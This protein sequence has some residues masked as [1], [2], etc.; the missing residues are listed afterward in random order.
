VTHDPTTSPDAPHWTEPDVLIVGA[1]ASGAA[2]AW[3]L[4][5]AG[6]RVVCLDQGG[7]VDPT[8]MPPLHDDWELRRLTS[9]SPDPNIRQL[10]EDY[11]VNDRASTFTPLMYNAVGGSTIHWSGHFPRYHP[12]DFRVHTLDGVADDWPLTYDELEP[13]FDLNDGVIGVSGLA[14]D[15]SQPPR[16]PR[17]TRP[18]PI[19]TMGETI[20]RGFDRLGWHWWVSDGA[21]ISEPYGEHR[22]PC[23]HC[24]P[25]DLGCPIAARSSADVTYWPQAVAFGVE[26]RTYCRVRE[27]T[28]DEQGRA[29][30]ALY[31]DREG[32]L[33][34]QTAP[35][36]I[37]ACNGVGTP[38][39]LLNSRSRHFPDGLANGS[40]L[41][42]KNLMFHPV[43]EVGGV[44]AE[45]LD[46]YKG[47]IGN[48]L[49]SH[50]FYETDL[51]R[52]FVRGYGMQV[53]RQ[54]G[55][56][57][58]AL[59]GITGQRIPWGRDHHRIFAERFK[60][61]AYLGIFGE[62]LPETI[63][64]VTLDPTLVD[65]H[66]IPAPLVRYRMSDNSK[67][68]MEHGVA[69]AT[70]VMIAAGATEVI[71]T[72]PYRPAGWHLLGTCRM[73]DHPLASV[74]DRWGRSHDVPNLY[75]VDGSIFV[76]SAAVNPTSTI[77][78]LALRTADFIQRER[79]N[80]PTG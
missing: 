64:D 50:E 71:S 7:W 29:R 6:F 72:N 27:I 57:N 62:D 11:P 1:G 60:H 45:E 54:S 74:V 51:R 39:L 23:N 14:G 53:T 8:S 41:V 25:C 35:I 26:L 65:A 68:M 59:G 52:G 63:N 19:G 12:S 76:T 42:G 78:A 46:S 36:V 3:S 24:G 47:P 4:G 40:G 15:P 44:F 77:Q 55:P 69:R 43:A 5:R 16:S 49:F 66:G 38:R 48:C 13:Y 28:V 80:L 33:H 34:E 67:K 58:T 32:R 30:G 61:M 22:R 10:P 9:F 17:Q 37:V 18:L 79:A 75:I 20:A 21:I 73:G 70:E 56:M 31:Y 2:V